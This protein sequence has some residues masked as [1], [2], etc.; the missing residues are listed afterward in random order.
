MRSIDS[1]GTVSNDLIGSSS[2]RAAWMGNALSFAVEAVMSIA[3]AA[4]LSFAGDAVMSIAVAAVL[5]I[6]VADELWLSVLQDCCDNLSGFRTTHLLTPVCIL[7][8]P[9]RVGFG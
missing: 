1:A 6:C 9:R 5:S 8:W 3:V 4:G 2:T 7:A